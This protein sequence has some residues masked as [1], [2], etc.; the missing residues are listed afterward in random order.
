MALLKLENLYKYYTGAQSVVVGLNG[1]NLSFEAGEFVA[2]T[3][4][5]GSGKSTL[6]HV[7]GGILPYENGELFLDGRPTSHYDGNDWERY[8]LE[9]ISFISQSYGILPGASVLSNVVSALRLTGMSRSE[10]HEQAE[11]ILKKVDLWTLRKRRAARLSS[12]QKQRLSIARA[13]AKPAPILLA[14][15]PT[16]NLDA[17]NSAK[18]IE[19]L[20]Q[21]A[22][23]RLVILITHEFSEAEDY[24]TR[25][26]ILQDGKVTSDVALHPM[27]TEVCPPQRTEKKK[28]HL[29]GYIAALQLRS[30]PVWC[31]TM[32]LLFALTAFAV[33]AFLGTFLSSLDDASTRIYDNA[34]FRNGDMKRIVVVREDGEEMTQED[35][36]ALLDL[37]YVVCG[38]R[39]GYVRDFYCAWRKDVDYRIDYA[40][41]NV[42]NQID[43]IW[44]QTSSV[45]FLNTKV[46]VQTVPVFAD[47]SDP[48]LT[49]GRLP[50]HIWE[51][52]AVGDESLIGQ[53]FSAYL[54][55]RKNWAPSDYIYLEVTVVG[56]TDFGS[57]LYFHE[58]MGRVLTV[59]L[60]YENVPLYLPADLADNENLMSKDVWDFYYPDC[61]PETIDW[62]LSVDPLTFTVQGTLDEEVL[63]KL[64]LAGYTLTSM[65]R[66][67]EVSEANFD[68]LMPDIYGN[69]ISLTIEDYAYCD[70]VL[71]EIRDAGYM[72]MSPFRESSN[73]QS[74]ELAEQRMQTL[75]ICLIAL[76]AVLIL[77]VIV[78][79]AMF[80][81][82]TESYRLLSNIGLRC[83]TAKGSVL[84]QFVL[85]TLLGEAASC[86]LLFYCVNRRVERIVAIQRYLTSSYALILFGVHFAA[87]IV[88]AVLVM[89]SLR[90]QVYPY[91][92]VQP[93]LKEV[94][95]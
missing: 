19:L 95:E 87:C 54:Q 32:L 41:D 79:R 1:I 35:M 37:D 72:G 49:A 34:A 2:I 77:Q 26:I 85:F 6:A 88:T 14:D 3:G 44:E 60:L 13:L 74:E 51:V 21:V 15:E 67:S 11:V 24:V 57:G 7:L 47:D 53:K 66:F 25:H 16:G 46:F 39:Y 58:D 36:D 78:L 5:S 76:L 80:G 55:D 62:S 69:Q 50:E 86:G 30:R 81:I 84:W 71:K 73:E 27:P 23:E 56:V 63:L 8:R 42:G 33:F 92:T 75:R 29:S 10:A 22:K 48:F 68:L 17:E 40:L 38:E 18:V 91:A 31:L 9:Q 64:K 94:A 70:R 59:D 83:K 90:K 82:Q 89:R 20:A 28:P 43:I 65:R 4:E 45:T 52:V 61:D 12:G 93:D